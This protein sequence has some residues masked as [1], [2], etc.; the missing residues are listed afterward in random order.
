MALRPVVA[1]DGRRRRPGPGPG[2]TRSAH[3]G[4]SATMIARIAARSS[5]ASSSTS[6]DCAVGQDVE[7]RGIAADEVAHRVDDRA[8]GALGRRVQLGWGRAAAQ[9]SMRRDRR[10]DVVGEGVG[11]D[12]SG[13]APHRS[14]PAPS[15]RTSAAVR[16]SQSGTSARWYGHSRR[17]DAVE[18][19]LVDERLARRGHRREQPRG[20]LRVAARAGPR[21]SD[22]ASGAASAIAVRRPDL[23]EG[24]LVEERADPRRSRPSRGGRVARPSP[25]TLPGWKSP[26]TRVSGS[27]H[28]ATAA[29]RTGR[30]AAKARRTSTIGRIEVGG[31]TLDQAADGRRQGRPAPVREAEGEE[32][33]DV[34][35][36]RGLQVDEQVDHPVELRA[37]RVVAIAARQLPHERRDAR[38]GRAGVGTGRPASRS[39]TAPSWAK[40]GGTA[41]SHAAVPSASG[42]AHRLERFHDRT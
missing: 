21:A 29:K 36:G 12:R 33:R 6:A 2:A 30:S 40:N 20:P 26:W 3:S 4:P 5:D 17:L 15:A 34:A 37:G 7:V 18:E 11:K 42:R 10:P 19:D 32:A 24:R 27:P 39:R 23:Q 8:V 1:V 35:G 31:T 41:L 14:T 9:A 28:A 22:R 25:R 38:H 13:H 16:C